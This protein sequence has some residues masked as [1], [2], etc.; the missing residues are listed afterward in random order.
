MLNKIKNF[1][2][3]FFS[4]LFSIIWVTLTAVILACPGKP[5]ALK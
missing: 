5:G 3:S 1:F 4:K 2:I